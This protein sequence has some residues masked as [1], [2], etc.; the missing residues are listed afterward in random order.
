MSHKNIS[1]LLFL[2]LSGMEIPVHNKLI[3]HVA[4]EVFFAK[5]NSKFYSNFIYA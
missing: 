3:I 2:S 1:F 5:N 4:Q